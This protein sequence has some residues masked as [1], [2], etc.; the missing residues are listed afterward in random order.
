MTQLTVNPLE[1]PRPAAR[2]GGGA[3]LFASI[4]LGIAC[5]AAILAGWTPIGFSIVTVFL[6]AGPHNW[7][8]FRYF[9]A[10]MPA[11]WGPLRGFFILAIGGVIALTALFALLPAMARGHD[12]TDDHW[13]TASAI[14]NSLFVA[15]VA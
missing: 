1:I 11:H 12:W 13:V 5:V 14:W 7:I 10:K 9:L 15:W 4:A 3:V 6:F 2:A 8:E